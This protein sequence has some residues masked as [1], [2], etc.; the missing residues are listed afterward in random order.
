MRLVT[1]VLPFVPVMAHQRSGD[2]R[3]ANSGSPMISPHAAEA[4]RKNSENSEMPGLA[5]QI[6]Y[7][8]SM[9][10]VPYAKRTPAPSSSRVR[11]VGADWAPP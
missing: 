6:S 5:T 9:S 10:S 11:S 1:V 3:H 8:P 7:A 4:L 2:R